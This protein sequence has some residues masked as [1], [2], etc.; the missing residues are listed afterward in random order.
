MCRQWLKISRDSQ[1]WKRRCFNKSPRVIA[2][3]LKNFE[4]RAPIP[5]PEPRVLELQRAVSRSITSS[6]LE[7]QS[8]SRANLGGPDQSLRRDI[9]FRNIASWDP[10]YPS[11]RVNWYDEYISRHSVLSTSWIQQPFGDSNG[12]NER[13]GIGGLGFKRNGNNGIVFAP[14]DDGSVCIWNIGSADGLPTAE[15]GYILARS[16]AGLLSIDDF[17]SNSKSAR[18]T[19]REIVVKPACVSIDSLQN[20]AYVAVGEDLNEIDIE[21]LR[22][23]SRERY[24]SEIYA[25]S[26]ASHST[27][28]TVG[29]SISLHI[30]DFRFP[31]NTQK[32][33][34]NSDRLE[35]FSS[36]VS[37]P[38]LHG[39]R[40][41]NSE[42]ND[43]ACHL[44][45]FQPLSILH[46]PTSNGSHD[47]QNG[48]ICVTGRMRSIMVYDRRTFPR[49]YGTIYSGARLCSLASAPPSSPTQTIIACG[50]YNGKGS[51]EIY[52]LSFTKPSSP[53]SSAFRNRVS[54]SSSKLLSIIPHGTRL[55][56]SDSNGILKWV[57][58]D[59]STPV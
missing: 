37:G 42:R 3:R 8:G 5:I 59:G 29:T 26:E 35:Q 31:Y 27:P 17:K 21:T 57:E 23:I 39:D 48:F 47:A 45:G 1:L 54:A 19:R 41:Q 56:F 14:L 2:E 30:H 38:G 55:V 58:R 7:K 22:V 6:N 9:K 52:P 33:P 20:K 40:H 25:L 49:L 43:A 46:L 10:S 51:L 36:L 32:E 34:G 44:P 15:N 11:E 53:A 24:T 28:L 16:K 50:E 4:P 18:L 12:S 13:R